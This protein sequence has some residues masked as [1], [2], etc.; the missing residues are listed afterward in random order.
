MLA[1]YVGALVRALFAIP[2]VL[3]SNA[4]G[5]LWP[6]VIVV[7]G[8]IIACFV[9]GWRVVIDKWKRASLIGFAAL[10]A[11][12]MSLFAYCALNTVYQD[13]FALSQKASYLRD[14]VDSDTSHEQLAVLKAQN[15]CAQALG[16]NE[17][18]GQQN[19]DQQNTIDHCQEEALRL[20][21]P[22]RQKTTSIFVEQSDGG[23][24][25]DGVQ[26][27]R[28]KV[29]ALTNKRVEPPFTMIVQCRVALAS[30]KLYPLPITLHTENAV[31]AGPG[32]WLVY[33]GLHAWTP[34]SPLFGELVYPGDPHVQT[35]V[36]CSIRPEQ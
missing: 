35:K 28:V 19:R 3:G 15:E 9:Y 20:L 22:R 11:C 4:L 24:T 25:K 33:I 29:L 12:Y 26:M 10:V 34:S 30:V 32:E 27:V 21:T 36:L 13:H 14:K 7:C 8:E 5:L 6:V 1:Y 17:V 16:E 23:K 18:L 31:R 2:H